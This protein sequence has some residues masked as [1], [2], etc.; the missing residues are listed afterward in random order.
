[1][2][3]V[4]AVIPFGARNAD[5]VS[6]AVARQLARRVVDRFERSGVLEAKPV[7][8]VAVD[9]QGGAGAVVFG[10][11][12][13][14]KLASEYA[15][16]VSATHALFGS[17]EGEVVRTQ[18]VRASDAA[19]VDTGETSVGDARLPY[20]EGEIALAAARALRAPLNDEAIGRLRIPLTPDP[21]A[22]RSFLVAMDLEMTATVLRRDQPEQAEARLREAGGAFLAALRADPGLDAAEERLLYLAAEYIERGQQERATEVLED[23]IG[24]KPRSWKAH[25]MLGDLRREAGLPSQAVVAFELSDSLHPLSDADQ[26]RLAQLYAESEAFDSAAARL[27]RVKPTSSQYGNAQAELGGVLLRKG[28]PGGAVAALER[29]RASGADGATT[30]TRL[31]QARAAAGDDRGARETFEESLSHDDGSWVVPATYAAHLHGGGELGRAIE[32]YRTAVDRGA[33]PSA[34]LN[35]ARALIVTEQR[36]AGA[37]Q[38]DALLSLSP[39]AETAAQAR[40]LRFGLARPGDE[41]RLEEAGQIAV[42]AREGDLDAARATLSEIASAASDLW[43]AHFG[44]GLVARRQGDAPGAEEA[45]RRALQLLPEQPD[46]EHE[47]GVALLM[48]GK[49]DEAVIALEEAAHHRPDDPGYVA[50]AGFAYMVA[51]NLHS[52][53]NRLEHARELDADDEI[54]KQYLEELEK[55]EHEAAGHRHGDG[56]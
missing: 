3:P 30:L 52:A 19:V 5:S 32:L 23:L 41:H 14:A 44:L 11:V 25:Y 34:R 55:R 37:E 13:E 1:M 51:G 15:T 28:D 53:R 18:L 48:Q 4:L 39:D 29:A 42:G 35:L 43:E 54:T 16:G 9:E 40:R 17:L 24:T 26:I 38:L 47:L 20:A 7:Y 2:R 45:F 33:P 6:A 50:D 10:S 8:L 36:D 22:Y 21:Q 31:A 56:D 49:I 12:P 46:A 27:R